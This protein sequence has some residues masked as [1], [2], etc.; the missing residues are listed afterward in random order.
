[1][2][3]QPEKARPIEFIPRFDHRRR[4]FGH[5]RAGELWKA[6]LREVIARVNERESG[7]AV[8]S[9]DI[10]SGLHAD[11]GEAQG[12]VIVADYTVTFTAPKPGLFLGGGARHTGSLRFG[13]SVLR[14]E[15]IEATRKGKAPL[16][17]AAGIYPNFRGPASP[18]GTKEPMAMR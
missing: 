7:S 3:S 8:V 12:E 11:T 13:T 10:P 17:R 14:R 15:L 18:K 2:I 9:V 4:A 6:R 1:M 16:E 5:G